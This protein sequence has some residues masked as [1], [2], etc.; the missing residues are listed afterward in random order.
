M[1]ILVTSSPGGACCRPMKSRVSL[2][3]ISIPGGKFISGSM[4]PRASLFLDFKTFGVR[5]SSRLVA[6]PG[7]WSSIF[8]E[9]SCNL[10]VGRNSPEPYFHPSST[11][12]NQNVLNR[13]D[14]CFGICQERLSGKNSSGQFSRIWSRIY[15]FSWK[16]AVYPFCSFL[17]STWCK[18]TFFQWHF[19]LSIHKFVIPAS[20]N[21]GQNSCFCHQ[22]HSLNK[23]KNSSTKHTF[24]Q[25]LS[26]LPPKGCSRKP[27]IRLLIKT[28]IPRESLHLLLLLS[29]F[30]RQS[31]HSATDPP[32]KEGSGSSE[33]YTKKRTRSS[34]ETLWVRRPPWS[35]FG[36][37]PPVVFGEH[38]RPC[39]VRIE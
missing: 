8:T 3:W 12:C 38:D 4:F 19:L 5:A 26:N 37:W 18:T 9:F 34:A 1:L 30:S 25:S 16:S 17:A 27:S 13:A 36:A 2:F 23:N 32:K 39:M 6:P 28:R 10:Y 7:C 33:N 15:S 29:S 22:G 21:Q 24:W 35:K 11:C 31:H 14:L 20:T